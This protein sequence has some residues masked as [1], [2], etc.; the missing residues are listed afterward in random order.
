MSC[1]ELTQSDPTRPAVNSTLL[2]RNSRCRNSGC[3]NSGPSSL[4]GSLFNNMSWFTLYSIECCMEVQKDESVNQQ[5]LSRLA[6]YSTREV[7]Q[8]RIAQFVCKGLATL[9]SPTQDI[10]IYMYRDLISPPSCQIST[11][12]RKLAELIDSNSYSGCWYVELLFLREFYASFSC[13]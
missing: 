8:M 6:V 4:Q 2:G 5:R 3:P 13:V 7:A 1:H 11:A 9:W 12:F 10:V